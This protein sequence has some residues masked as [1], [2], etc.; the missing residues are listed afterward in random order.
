MAATIGVSCSHA[1]GGKRYA[2][3]RAA[4]AGHIS[5]C[6]RQAL[7]SRAMLLPP[8]PHSYLPGKGRVWRVY[9]LAGLCTVTTR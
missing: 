8:Q 3:R 7:L 1:H 9:Q 4:H 5:Y 2:P 6:P